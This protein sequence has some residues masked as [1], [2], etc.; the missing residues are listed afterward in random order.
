MMWRA[1][2]GLL[3]GVL[4]IMVGV[5]LAVDYRGIATRHIGLAMRVVRPFSPFRRT[6]WTHD[7]LARRR[8]RFIAFDRLFGVLII[9]LGA[10]ALVNGGY[11]LLRDVS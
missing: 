10:V 9:L 1:L 8:A 6:G 2:L 11:L 3:W 7:R 4:L 5:A